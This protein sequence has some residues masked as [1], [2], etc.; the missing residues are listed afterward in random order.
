MITPIVVELT[1]LSAHLTERLVTDISAAPVA[2]GSGGLA[3]AGRVS[4]RIRGDRADGRLNLVALQ[5]APVDAARA[6]GRDAA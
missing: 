2:G 1:R 6:L 5:R 3:S 4:P